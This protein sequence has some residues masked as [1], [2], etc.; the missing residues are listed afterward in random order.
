MYSRAIHDGNRLAH[1]GILIKLKQISHSQLR[2][3]QKRRSPRG[4][5][6]HEWSRNLLKW[7]R[8]PQPPI[9]SCI[10][11]DQFGCEGFTTSLH[12]S[13]CEVAIFFQVVYKSCDDSNDEDIR[14]DAYQFDENVVG[15]IIFIAAKSVVAKSNPNT[16]SGV[17][18]LE[19]MHLKELPDEAV[20]FM[21]H[22]CAKTLHTICVP[23]TWLNRKMSCIPKNLARLQSKIYDL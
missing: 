13:F 10:A 8:D 17:D 22:I 19:V 6:T 7:A 16:V 1:D 2:K 15:E 20:R 12:D 5:Q 21:A 23:K 4:Q 18:G 3:W 14:H 9:L 11:S